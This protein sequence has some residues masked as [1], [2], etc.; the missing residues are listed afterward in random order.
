MRPCCGRAQGIIVASN[1]GKTE[2]NKEVAG[3]TSWYVGLS[4]HLQCQPSV[5]STSRN[6]GCTASSLV[7][8]RYTWARAGDGPSAWAPVV[9]VGD[10]GGVLAPRLAL[11][12]TSCWGGYLGSEPADGKPTRV[13]AVRKQNPGCYSERKSSNDLG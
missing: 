7:A 10:P 13:S 4:R 8:C 3:L 5:L 1:K 11:L 2:Q 12:T 9:L 6:P